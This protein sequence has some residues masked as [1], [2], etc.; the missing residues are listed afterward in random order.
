M[1]LNNRLCYNSFTVSLNIWQTPCELAR[2]FDNII[3]GRPPRRHLRR[4]LRGSWNGRL[5]LLVRHLALHRYAHYSSIH[6]RVHICGPYSEASSYSTSANTRSS[7]P[8]C[9]PLRGRNP[10]SSPPSGTTGDH[11]PER[12]SSSNSVLEIQTMT[13]ENVPC[14]RFG[15][16]N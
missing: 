14:F 4:R 10:P 11:H 6:R 3:V 7:S 5:C 15:T 2:S 1:S 16:G 8:S 9:L 12:F 13:Q